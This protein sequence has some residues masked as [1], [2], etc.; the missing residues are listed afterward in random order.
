MA[1]LIVLTV[2][3]QAFAP[4]PNLP[5]PP[6]HPNGQV[7]WHLVH[8]KCVPDQ[9]DKSDPAPCVLV[10]LTPDEANGYV[11]LKDRTGVAQ[12]LV[13]PTAK[14]TGIEDRQIYASGAT[15]Y[16]AD[17]WTAQSFVDGSLGG[18]LPRDQ[19]SIA[20]NSIYGRSQDQLH[21]HVDC[22]DFAVRD[23]LNALPPAAA[24]GRWSSQPVTLAGHGYLVMRLDGDTL[25][26]ANPFKLLVRGVAAAKR[27]PGAWTLVL[28][29][30]QT[31]KPGF[32]LLA[33]EADPANG[34]SGSG[35]EL[36]DHDCTAERAA[37]APSQ[38]K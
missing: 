14:V 13:L 29:G 21:L 10:D 22:I 30:A 38:P 11:V 36:Q 17:A 24:A 31:P 6:T 35:E 33:M 25:G 4:A 9:R 34:N 7:L 26:A 20:V 5:P 27:N 23:A 18:T 15:N 8:D 16:F 32:Y 19:V 1:G 3:L 28:V 12:H 2:L 37:L